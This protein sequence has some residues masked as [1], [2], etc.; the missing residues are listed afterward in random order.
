MGT[1]LHD[2]VGSGSE[3]Q[4][5][6]DLKPLT[7]DE[8]VLELGWVGRRA[9]EL[10]ERGNDT[11]AD[12]VEFFNRRARL[13]EHLGQSALALDARVKAEQARRAWASAPPA[14]TAR[15]PGASQRC[16]TARVLLLSTRS[17]TD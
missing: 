15:L 17:R 16:P 2:D 13:L 7:N 10:R 5:T 6:E 3:R 9:R 8:A 11:C 12:W 14:G 4:L 1:V